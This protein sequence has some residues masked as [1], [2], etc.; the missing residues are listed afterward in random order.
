L[1]EIKTGRKK[2]E[3]D[4]RALKVTKHEKELF[5]P[6]RQAIDQAD[7]GEFQEVQEEIQHHRVRDVEEL[8][9]Q[10]RGDLQNTRD[11]INGKLAAVNTGV[12]EIHGES[13]NVSAR[14]LTIT[15]RY[16]TP[17]PAPPPAPPPP[18]F[19][20]LLPFDAP[21]PLPTAEQST[22][23]LRLEATGLAPH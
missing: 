20:P 6:R 23:T 8:L 9:A 11:T 13:W 1:A 7:A 22:S 16:A 3:E 15:S 21:T 17:P 5:K 12:N 2:E 19:V 14:Q 10:V 4:D 18:G